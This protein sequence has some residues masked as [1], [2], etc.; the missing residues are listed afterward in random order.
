MSNEQGEHNAF[1]RWKHTKIG[2]VTWAILAGGIAYVFGSMAIDS[3]SF[4]QWG[5][6]VLFLADA[7]YNL[8]QL[9]RKFVGRDNHP[10][11]A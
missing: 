8:G 3:G 6:T 9:I 1:V 10:N 2:R 4:L 5:L 11:Q 7:L